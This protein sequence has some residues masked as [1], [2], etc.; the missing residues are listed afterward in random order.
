MEEFSRT[1]MSSHPNKAA[2][3]CRRIPT[4]TNTK[5]IIRTTR[6][7]IALIVAIA[8]T[9]ASAFTLPTTPRRTST[10]TA[11]VGRGV[12][13]FRA[14]TTPSLRQHHHHRPTGAAAAVSLFSTGAAAAAD[15]RG[16]SSNVQVP[17]KPDPLD[18][19]AMI[20]YVVG[21]VGQW[22]T[23][24]AVLKGVDALLSLAS[25]KFG[26]VPKVLPVW[27][28]AIGFYVFNILTSKFSWLPNRRTDLRKAQ[29]ESSTY[30]EKIAPNW[31][32]PGW[33]FGIMWPL[34]VFGL[35]AYTAAMVVSSTAQYACPAILS[36]MAH[37]CF[38]SLWNTM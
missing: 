18:V 25:N 33:V 31:T 14:P 26:M 10:T 5:I 37:L 30:N 11:H 36:L 9:T 27:M 20:K 4:R 35:R 8:I 16:P 22:A 32:P 12:A 7:L 1:I 17:Y 2:T 24:W 3:A 23:L 21:Y 19:T 34:Y 38:G 29:Q 6:L 13:L 15:G 28:N